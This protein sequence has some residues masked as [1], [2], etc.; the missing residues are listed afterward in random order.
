MNKKEEIAYIAFDI[1]TTGQYIVS[2]DGDGDCMFAIG[3]AIHPTGESGQ[4]AINMKKPKDVSWEK[5]WEENNWEMLCWEEFWCKHEKKLDWMQDPKNI[6]IVESNQEMMDHVVK[7]I[8]RVEAKYKKVIHLFNTICFD[9]V[10]IEIKMMEAGYNSMLYR[11]SGDGRAWGR[12]VGSYLM[13]VYNLS[14]ETPSK[15]VSSKK[16]KLEA[17]IEGWS[18]KDA[19]YPKSDAEGILGLFLETKKVSL[20]RELKRNKNKNK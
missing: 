15:T 1:E 13:G 4:V 11:R 5:W 9:S 20:S 12:E 6:T 7:V 8:K 10:W 3:W 18:P 17:L 2:P 14:P 16:R 19:H